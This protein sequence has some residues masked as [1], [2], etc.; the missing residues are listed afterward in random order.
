MFLKTSFQSKEKKTEDK[1]SLQ[2]KKENSGTTDAL[3]DNET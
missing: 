3:F 2:K 1:S